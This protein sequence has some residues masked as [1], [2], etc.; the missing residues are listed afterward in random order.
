MGKPTSAIRLSGQIVA[1]RL[2]LIETEAV[3]ITSFPQTASSIL[4]ASVVN[5]VLNEHHR[6]KM[7]ARVEN[8]IPVP[9]EIATFLSGQIREQNFK[10]KCKLSTI[11]SPLAFR[12]NMI[13]RI[14]HN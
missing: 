10:H 14:V 6:E 5:L 2:H 8:S 13:K 3:A 9:L 11:P 7:K 1:N 4:N 12:Q